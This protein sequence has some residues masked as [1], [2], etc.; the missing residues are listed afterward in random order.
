VTASSAFPPFLSPVE[1]KISGA[2]YIADT[3][4]DLKRAPF[5][6]NV[7]LADGGVYDNLGLETAWKRCR[8]VLV[9]DGGGV[10]PDEPQPA[11]DWA[12]HSYRI[13]NL[14]DNQVRDLRKRQLI[15]SFQD[16]ARLGAYWGIRTDIS[17]YGLADS[18]PFPHADSLALAASPTRLAAIDLTLQ[19]QIINWGYAVTDAALRAHVNQT[20][21]KP[22]KLPY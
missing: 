10:T 13:L 3:G 1:L 18:L 20:F 6:T 12:R 9:S 22:T 11:R 17:N 7:F 5:T 21:P 4:L 2:D 8:T 14:L 15:G 19:E 16:G